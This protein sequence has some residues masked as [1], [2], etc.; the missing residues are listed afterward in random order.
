MAK[1]SKPEPETKTYSLKAIDNQ[2]LN[3]L[4][5]TYFTNLSNFLSYIA[6]ERWAYPVTERTTFKVED[7]KVIIAEADPP[8]EQAA[9]APTTSEALKGK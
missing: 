1:K 5:Q 8:K 2:M 7:G 6:L 9:Q 3:V 4:Q